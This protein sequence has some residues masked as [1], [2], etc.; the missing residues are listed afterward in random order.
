[1]NPGVLEKWYVIV[2][3]PKHEKKVHAQLQKRGVNSYLPLYSSIRQW[4]DRKKKL[5]LPLFS[6]YIFVRIDSKEQF[7]VLEVPGV[8]RF[9][10]FCGSPASIPDDYIISLKKILANEIP[11]EFELAQT[12]EI[13]QNVRI[14][15]GAMSGITGTVIKFKNGTKLAVNAHVIGQSLIIQVD[16]SL[17]EV[18]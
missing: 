16:P 11:F 7:K 12:I 4:S 2:V 13:N 6:C 18:I 14:K 17:L 1:M 5:T 15:R 10:T 9:I 8:T 3:P